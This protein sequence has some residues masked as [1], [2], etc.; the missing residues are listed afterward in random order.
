MACAAGAVLLAADRPLRASATHADAPLSARIVHRFDFDE[1]AQ[2]NLEPVPKYWVPI[3]HPSFPNFIKGEFDFQVGRLGA[4]AFHVGCAGRDAGFQYEGPATRVRPGIAHSVEGFVRPDQ[5][6]HARACLSAAYVDDQG[7]PLADTLVR[8]EFIGAEHADEWTRV[9]LYLG[10]APDEARTVGLF[11]WVLQHETWERSSRERRPI[12]LVD[13]HGGAWFDDITIYALPRVSFDIGEDDAGRDKWNSTRNPANI[14]PPGE[15]QFIRLEVADH[16]DEE[17]AASVVISA[18]HGTNIVTRTF[19]AEG[20]RLSARIPLSLLRPGLYRSELTL[21]SGGTTIMSRSLAFAK[22]GPLHGAGRATDAFG[23][24]LEPDLGVEAARDLLLLRNQGVREAKIPVWPGIGD[25]LEQPARRDQ[26]D[27]LLQDL[28]KDGYS[29]TAVLAEPPKRLTAQYSGYRRSILDLLADDPASWSSTLVSVAAPYAALFRGWQIG[30][31]IGHAPANQP[32]DRAASQ[33]DEVL[34]P[35]VPAPRL[36][37][38]VPAAATVSASAARLGRVTFTAGP[39]W[40]PHGFEQLVEES[41]AQG[42]AQT[43]VLV[44]P[45]PDDRFDR[46]PRLADWAKRLI[47]AR[48]AGADVVFSPQTWTSSGLESQRTVVPTEEYIVLRTIADVIGD[49]SPGPRLNLGEE[50]YCLVFYSDQ[51]AI[52]AAWDEHAPP[53]GR[54]LGVQLG[55]AA[56]QIDLWGNGSTLIQAE[57]GAQTI[58][59]GRTPVLIDGADRNLIELATGVRLDPALVNSSNEISRHTLEWRYGGTEPVAGE[60]ELALPGQWEVLPRT[61]RFTLTPGERTSIPITLHHPHNEPAGIKKL[62]AKL[63]L[64]HGPVLNVPL[65]VEVALPGLEVRG[66]AIVE[67]PDLVLT[68]LVLNKSDRVFHLRGSAAVPGRERQYRPFTNLAPGS[69]QRTEYRFKDGAELA[70]R[71]ALLTLR[72]LNDRPGTQTIELWVP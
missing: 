22:L 52:L 38:A 48:H 15:P 4:P 63:R 26:I 65:F 39:E 36:E 27:L 23:I 10:E 17:F 37:T 61:S 46:V 40:P 1:R 49:A 59:L 13:V 44:L 66:R 24:V 57:D 19:T 56:K 7:A 60:C 58:R 43:A 51:E 71:R 6:R 12:H 64:D 41:R 28:L 70:G 53:E 9:D 69:V 29:L 20:R 18:A 35:Y 11:A 72:E 21:A 33:L 68:Q 50:V 45:L 5:L 55:G 67:G 3:P 47:S 8:S 62:A 30:P 34:R 16:M 14:I 25:D 54:T 2:G 42:Y 32:L 31:N